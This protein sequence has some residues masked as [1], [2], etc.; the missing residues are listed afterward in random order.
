MAVASQSRCIVEAPFGWVTVAGFA[1]RIATVD[2]SRRRPKGTRCG[3][4]RTQAMGREIERYL[5]NP[6]Y[7][8]SA[9]L[10]RTGTPFQRRV[11]R[12]LQRIPS[13][14]VRTY[15]EVARALRT[16]P[17]A[18]GRACAANPLPLFVP[19]HRVVAADGLGGYSAGAAGDGLRIKRWLLR[20]EGVL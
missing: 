5:V 10:V 20:H 15:G 9:R 12:Y 6:R 2:I 1:D 18:V 17:R 11:W 4:A 13:G 8:P 19:C 14:A 16:A 7:R 3:G